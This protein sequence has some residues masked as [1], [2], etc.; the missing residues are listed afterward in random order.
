VSGRRSSARCWQEGK[1]IEPA[2]GDRR[3]GQ[4]GKGRERQSSDPPPP[5]PR[6]AT[7]TSHHA[8]LRKQL[9][10]V[11]TNRRRNEQIEGSRD[12]GI[13]VGDHAVTSSSSKRRIAL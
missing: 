8:R 5:P 10:R 3:S 2:G 4:Q 7:T 11:T 9:L 12:D 13:F 6:E 1:Q